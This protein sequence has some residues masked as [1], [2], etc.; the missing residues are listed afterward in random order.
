VES[1]GRIVDTSQRGKVDSIAGGG[2]IEERVCGHSTR[3][4]VG[5]SH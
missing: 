4:D 2:C 1:R 3:E 5:V